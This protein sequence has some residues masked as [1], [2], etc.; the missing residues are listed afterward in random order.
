MSTA[1]LDLSIF[2]KLAKIP[3]KKV[4]FWLAMVF[5]VWSL[6]LLAKLTWYTVELFLV[7]K[8]VVE[9]PKI[10]V[11]ATAPVQA[12]F[13]I[14]AVSAASIFG[15]KSKE[16][17]ESTPKPIQVE[18][19]K[20]STLDVKLR[21][22]YVSEDRSAANA[23]L[24]IKRGEQEVLFIGDKFSGGA[25]LIEVFPDQVIISRNGSREA[26]KMEEF[27]PGKG[28]ITSYSPSSNAAIGNRS[29]R[30]I[31]RRNDRGASRELQR[32]RKDFKENPASISQFITGREHMVNGEFVGFKI[33]PGRNR[34]LF[35]KLGLRRDDV[36]TSI[37]G[38]SLTNMQ[39]AMTMMGQI[40]TVQEISLTV[41]RG[42]EEVTMQFSVGD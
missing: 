7:G 11:G 26:I 29:S 22:V 36:V 41:L 2:Q 10:T 3:I 21:G 6:Y 8:P 23:T 14:R 27:D 9:R 31:D 30:S 40:D 38:T 24:E 39:A 15:E 19:V 42:S 17:V 34:R 5:S 20:E 12:K 32:L 16:V 37:N 4:S 28:G 35:N 13:D 25:E 33:S 1:A 18:Q